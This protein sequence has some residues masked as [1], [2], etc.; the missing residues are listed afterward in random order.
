[1]QAV[2]KQKHEKKKT[3]VVKFFLKLDVS[4]VSYYIF[5]KECKEIEM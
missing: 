4:F 3:R 5:G 1:M 2:R